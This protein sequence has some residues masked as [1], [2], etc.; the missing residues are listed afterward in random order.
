VSCLRRFHLSPNWRAFSPSERYPLLYVY[1]IKRA[2]FNSHCRFCWFR[3]GDV[4][5]SHSWPCSHV[6]KASILVRHNDEAMLG[7]IQVAVDIISALLR[8]ASSVFS[9]VCSQSCVFDVIF[10]ATLKTSPSCDNHCST[11]LTQ[12]LGL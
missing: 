6:P 9:Q 4:Q 1:S 10:G 2:F 5:P 3:N 11:S 12:P 8:N 7:L